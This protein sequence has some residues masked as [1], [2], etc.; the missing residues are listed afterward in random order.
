MEFG[1][2]DYAML[3]WWGLIEAPKGGKPGM[4]RVT[5]AGERF[6]RGP[7]NVHSHVVMY[8]DRMLRFDGE[9]TDIRGAL[10][11]RFD[12]DELMGERPSLALS[13]EAPR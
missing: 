1:S 4:W 8:D 10:G 3:K 6:V 13:G 9:L 11:D 2:G 5:E 7:L 12:Y